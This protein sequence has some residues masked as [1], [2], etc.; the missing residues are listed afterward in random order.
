[1]GLY[2]NEEMKIQSDLGDESRIGIEK[3]RLG[4]RIEWNRKEERVKR[5][6]KKVAFKEK[7]FY[8][9]IEKV[10]WVKE[11]NRSSMEKKGKWNR[12]QKKEA[13]KVKDNCL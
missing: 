3:R 10:E 13:Q 9:K 8:E 11:S 4:K 5:E 12:R 1:M 2:Q 6:K 7:K